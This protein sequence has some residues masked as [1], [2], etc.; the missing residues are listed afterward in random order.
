MTNKEIIQIS[1][2]KPKKSQS[3]VPLKL[4]RHLEQLLTIRNLF[5]NVTEKIL[6]MRTFQQRGAFFSPFQVVNKNILGLDNVH[7]RMEYFP[8]YPSA[9]LL[10]P[11]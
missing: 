5:A 2:S 10:L 8:N 4:L 7:Y 3:C 1:K 11:L 9:S 6:C